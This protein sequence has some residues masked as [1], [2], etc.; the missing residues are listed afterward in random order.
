MIG[1]HEFYLANALADLGH[2]VVIFTSKKSLNYGKMEANPRSRENLEIKAFDSFVDLSEAP[3]VPLMLPAIAQADLDVIH[4]HEYFQFCSFYGALVARLRKMPL[5]LTQHGYYHPE[6]VTKRTAIRFSEISYGRFVWESAG[7]IIA[8]ANST[9]DFLTGTIGIDAE[10]IEV[11][12]TGVDTCC[13]SPS[14]AIDERAVPHVLIGRKVILFVGRLVR[15]K[16]VKLLIKAFKGISEEFPDVELCIVGQGPEEDFLRS[17]SSRLNVADRIT[18]IDYV[19]HYLMNQL[20]A[21]STVFVLPSLVEP[22][23]NVL[24][25]AIAS[26]RPVV[27]TR[28][29]GIP[30]IISNGVNGILIKPSSTRELETALRSVLEDEKL[31]SRLGR[32]GRVVAESK[33]SWRVIANRVTSLYREAHNN[34]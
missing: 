12:P 17:L 30:D 20:Y 8:I 13:F 4:V 10:K 21:V 22:L 24:L 9:K 32:G 34:G 14:T 1:G 18:W 15:Y 31:A 26:G 2:E 25:E 5:I 11:I 23:G 19:P 27:A 3:I 29:G 7:R 28:V 16:G 33:F 6:N